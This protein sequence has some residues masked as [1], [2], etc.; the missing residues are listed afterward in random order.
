MYL[1]FCF[2]NIISKTE[3]HKIILHEFSKIIIS[4]KVEDKITTKIDKNRS[5]LKITDSF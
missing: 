5:M 1:R 3:T 4:T 2:C